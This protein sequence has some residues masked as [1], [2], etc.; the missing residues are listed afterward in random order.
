MLDVYILL[1]KLSNQ[2]NY[3]QEKIKRRM[4]KGASIITK[5]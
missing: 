1:V 2:G 5:P 3:E 4:I